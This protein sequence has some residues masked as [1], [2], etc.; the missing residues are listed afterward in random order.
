MLPLH[1][2]TAKQGGLPLVDGGMVGEAQEM[3]L[4]KRSGK[5]GQKPGEQPLH[6][7]VVVP[8]GG[9]KREI[10]GS[11][12]GIGNAEKN[13]APVGKIPFSLQNLRPQKRRIF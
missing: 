6:I 11:R 2:K 1:S 9:I 12:S 10:V 13:G 5:L 8:G 3:P 4:G 7:K